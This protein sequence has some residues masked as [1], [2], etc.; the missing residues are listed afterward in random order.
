MSFD[1]AAYHPIAFDP[2]PLNTSLVLPARHL[3]PSIPWIAHQKAYCQSTSL[4]MIAEWRSGRPRKLGFFNWL[5]GFTY[6][7]G[8]LKGSYIFLPYD[9]PEAGL[10]FAAAFLGLDHQYLVGDDQDAYIKAMKATLVADRPV[11]IMVDSATMKG[12]RD[13][14]SPHSVVVAGY[15]EDQALVYET[16]ME[17]RRAEGTSGQPLPWTQLAAAAQRVSEVYRYPWVFQF[18]RFDPCEARAPDLPVVC[19]RNGQSLMGMDAP[20]V[21]TGAAAIR[22]IA[23]QIAGEDGPVPSAWQDLKLFLEYGAYTRTD[24]S[25]YL[26]D[27]LSESEELAQVASWLSEAGQCYAR[28][29]TVLDTPEA[30]GGVGQDPS[31]VTRARIAEQLGKEL[32][33]AAALEEDAGRLLIAAAART[34]AAVGVGHG[35]GRSG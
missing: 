20:H 7:A 3:V 4:Q 35:D 16:R 28:M 29:V 2:S 19:T 9:D 13:Y 8:H 17:D 26:R 6:G 24:N 32:A 18:T 22:S 31:P 30:K 27:E 10:R 21:A 14:F 1:W 11:R 12:R 23:R 34:D 5:M 25:G 15:D 33:R